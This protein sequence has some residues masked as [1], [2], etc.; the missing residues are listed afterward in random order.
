MFVEYLV[1]IHLFFHVDRVSS[2]IVVD[3]K[4]PMLYFKRISYR[5]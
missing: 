1:K 2:Q 4:Q 5:L 3:Y